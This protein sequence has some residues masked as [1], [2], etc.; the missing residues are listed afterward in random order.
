VIGRGIALEIPP[1]GLSF[2]RWFVALSILSL[3][4]VPILKANWK[5]IRSALPMLSIMALLGV[6]GFNTLV[7][8][9]LQSTTA[10]N[11]LLLLSTTPVII[12]LLSRLLFGQA[13]ARLQLG[14]VAISLIGV[15]VLIARGDLS[16]LF[17]RQF[18]G[19]DFW[20]LMAIFVWALYSVLLKRRP[21]GLDPLAFLAF[22]VVVGAVGLLP[23]LLWEI[24]QGRV[25]SVDT[26]S[27]VT[28]LYVAIF[29]SILAFLF[30]NRAV[31]EVGANR[32]GQFL[33]LMP[34]FG[35]ILAMIFLDEVIRWFH[36]FG[37]LL[38]MA[39][40]YLSQRAID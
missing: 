1:I 40:I 37:F 36:L 5:R 23:L 32:A 24:G 21:E 2:W 18:G 7:Y 12:I 15:V 9:G 20:I 28:I 10:T 34:V 14:G 25:V 17:A 29:P 38:I 31:A 26:Q 6:T 8:I 13:I 16:V 33:Y 3:F 35:S 4:C 30:W 22:T 19:G 39:G 11:G 27:V